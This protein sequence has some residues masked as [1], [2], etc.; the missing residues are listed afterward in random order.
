MWVSEAVRG[1]VMMM[2]ERERK[3][4]QAHFNLFFFFMTIDCDY[5]SE[6]QTGSIASSRL[7]LQLCECF[8]FSPEGGERDV[9]YCKTSVTLFKNMFLFTVQYILGFK[10]LWALVKM[11]VFLSLLE[12]YWQQHWSYMDK[13]WWSCNVTNNLFFCLSGCKIKNIAMYTWSSLIIFFF[14]IS[15]IKRLV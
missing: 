14:T 13:A 7:S 1:E 15:M 3:V 9:C 10:S 11:H 5:S 8:V 6:R 4:S 12:G 2:C